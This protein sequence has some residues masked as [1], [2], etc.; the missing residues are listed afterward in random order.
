MKWKDWLTEG[1][2]RYFS[3]AILSKLMHVPHAHYE[4]IFL[5][6]NHSREKLS[7]WFFG[8]GMGRRKHPG[9]HQGILQL[10]Q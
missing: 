3:K 7:T 6:C 5:F 10:N 9:Y 2:E 8:K 4:V 1:E